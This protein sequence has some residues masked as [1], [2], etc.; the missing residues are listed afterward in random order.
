VS[1]DLYEGTTAVQKVGAAMVGPLPSGRA[2]EQDTLR[3]LV[4]QAS[5]LVRIYMRIFP[6]T[7]CQCDRVHKSNVQGG[8]R[9]R[10]HARGWWR[11]VLTCVVLEFVLW[12]TAHECARQLA[13]RPIQPVKRRGQN[14]EPTVLVSRREPL[15]PPYNVTCS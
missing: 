10:T 14:L 15:V 9:A 3:R 5:A 4:Q 8:G 13:T 12:R 7:K 11:W 2:S 1:K 6:P